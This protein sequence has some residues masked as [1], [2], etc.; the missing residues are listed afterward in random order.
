MKSKRHAPEQVIRKVA[1]SDEILSKGA[2]ASEVDRS[3]GIT[4]TTWHRWKNTYGDIKVT[5]SKRVKE[6]EAENERLKK[7]VADQA[8]DVDMLKEIASGH[9]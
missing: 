6:L 8:F 4:E 3:F 1:E 2:T 5:E 7:I 9:F